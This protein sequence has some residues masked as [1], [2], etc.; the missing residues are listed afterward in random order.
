MDFSAA[1]RLARADWSAERNER[2]F[3]PSPSTSG[4]NYVLEVT[5]QGEADAETG[6]L[7][8]LKQLKQ[9]MEDEVGQRFD[10]R[11]LNEDTP[12]F[13]AR[14]PTPENLASLIFCLLERAL[15]A[16]LLYE[17]RLSPTE[18]LTIEVRR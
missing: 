12:Y 3:G 16:G 17:V 6:M 14:V 13:Q 15:P 7:I 8:D 11:N 10:H 18:D 9:I 2:V 1:H 4:H 5:L